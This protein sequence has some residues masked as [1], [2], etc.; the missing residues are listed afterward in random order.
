VNEWVAGY[1]YDILTQWLTN[2]MEPSASWE[3]NSRSTSQEIL[4][5]LWNPVFTRARHWSLLWARCIQ[6]TTS[7]TTSL[8][9]ILIL[10]FYL[11]LGSS[12]WSLPFRFS[13]QKVCMLFSLPHA[14]PMS[15]PSHPSW[16]DHPN[17]IWW[18]VQFIKL[19]IMQSSSA[20]RHFI[21]LK[22]KYS[23]QH[24]VLRHPESM[25]FP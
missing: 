9:S 3:A 24:P 2:N 11:H 16:L 18:S 13:T 15:R 19:L 1:K 4:S 25:L 5:L 20:S 6:S 14:C 21:L 22:Y 12:K 10:S 7:H 23:P 17:N 8:R